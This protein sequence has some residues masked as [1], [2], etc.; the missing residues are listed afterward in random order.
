MLRLETLEKR[1]E[2]FKYVEMELF[3]Q[4]KYTRKVTFA[5]S[6]FGIADTFLEGHRLGMSH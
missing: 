4:V 5:V 2:L 3:S 6:F 1:I